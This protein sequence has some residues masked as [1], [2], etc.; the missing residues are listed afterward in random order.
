MIALHAPLEFS[1]QA[2]ITAVYHHQQT[3]NEGL[4]RRDDQNRYIAPHSTPYEMPYVF[5]K[6]T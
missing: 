6:L 1:S 2:V 3:P 4:T 5:G